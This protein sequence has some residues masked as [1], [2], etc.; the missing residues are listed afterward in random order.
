VCEKI[1]ARL[2]QR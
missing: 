1:N 2:A